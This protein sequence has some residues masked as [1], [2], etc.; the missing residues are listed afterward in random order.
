MNKHTHAI[1]CLQELTFVQLGRLASFSGEEEVFGV[2]S[3]ERGLVFGCGSATPALLRSLRGS[4]L[5]VITSD[6]ANALQVGQ[7]SI[8]TLVL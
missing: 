3:V 8:R 6:P 5:S 1:Q 7:S 4:F 2:S